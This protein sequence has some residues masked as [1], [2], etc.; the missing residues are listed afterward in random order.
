MSIVSFEWSP[1]YQTLDSH[2]GKNPRRNTTSLEI[3]ITLVD[4]ADKR[5]ERAYMINESSINEKIQ[6]KAFEAI[7]N[8]CLR[9]T[10]N[11]E[12]LIIYDE[13]LEVYSSALTAA[14]VEQDLSTTF[15]NIPKKYQIGLAKRI[16]AYPDDN[17]LPNP[18][19][20]SIFNCSAILNLLDGDLATGCVRRLILQTQRSR[21]C[22]L[23]HIPGISSAILSVLANS[24]FDNIQEKCE[25]VAW[26]LGNS[27]TAELIT[28][29]S[30][31]NSYSIKLDIGGWKNEP[32]MSPGVI[33]SGS[34]GNVPPG[35]TFCCPNP[36]TINGDICIN[37]SVP[38][39]VL[40]IGQEIILKFQQGRL[41]SW[42]APKNSPAIK[43]FEFQRKKAE[44]ND[45][46]NWNV[47]AELG[48]GLNA[49]ITKLTGNSLFDEKALNTIHI[50]IG[51]NTVFGHN[52]KSNIHADLATWNPTL[53]IDNL[54]VMING[55]LQIDSLSEKRES[56]QAPLANIDNKLRVCLKEAEL[57]EENG[58]L[59]RRLC[60]AGRVGLV[61]MTSPNLN[62]GLSE[63]YHIFERCDTPQ[64]NDLITEYPLIAG[65]KCEDLLNILN[66]YDC[67]RLL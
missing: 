10:A 40:D 46:K 53:I 3:F 38:G 52:N 26:I 16:S 31:N 63:L 49:A 28:F 60:K 65:I 56:W 64:V 7:L 42:H 20:Y 14:I 57:Q 59:Y 50:A 48:I 55:N 43:F 29:D 33:L 2:G 6:K 67:L 39:Y 13:S 62:R 9:V 11:E 24:D 22:R 32:M 8:K 41:I 66:H 37:G 34:W 44:E 61:K 51:D 5:T 1:C 18:I 27:K 17:W 47:F 45:D 21:E 58:I 36:D 25:L 12:F 30:S 23:A 4:N 54:N 19:I 15:I 35:E